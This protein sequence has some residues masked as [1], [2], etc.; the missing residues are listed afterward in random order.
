MTSHE[1]RKPVAN[2]LGLAEV[3]G[4]PAMNAEEME[5]L[6]KAIKFSASELDNFTRKLIGFIHQI[7]SKHL[8][9]E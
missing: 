6:F 8:N 1:V 9:K 4:D 7:K 3:A 2:L 5:E